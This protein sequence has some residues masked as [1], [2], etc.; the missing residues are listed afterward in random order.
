MTVVSPPNGAGAVIVWDRGEWVPKEDPLEGLAKGKLLF[1]LK[2]YKL[3]G[4]W[5]LVKIKKSEKEWLLI[6]KRDAAAVPGWDAEDHPQSVKTGRTN[7][8]VKAAV[9][10]MVAQ[11]K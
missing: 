6:K 10:Y 4:K 7:D 1:E 9:D 8:E 2:G 3:K 5:T 11:A